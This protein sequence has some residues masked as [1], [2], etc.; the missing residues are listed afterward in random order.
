MSYT[1][2]MYLQDICVTWIGTD[3]ARIQYLFVRRRKQ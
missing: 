1:T 3:D 2:G